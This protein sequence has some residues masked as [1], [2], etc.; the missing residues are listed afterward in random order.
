MV[1][2]ANGCT[3]A[4][5]GVITEPDEVTLS[6]APSPTTVKLGDE[7]QL[8]TTTN[9]TGILTYNWLPDNGLSCND[10]ANPVFSGIVSQTYTV[11]VTTLKGC[12]GVANFV[13]T[14][15]P[16]Y[17]VFIP[18]VFTPDNSTANDYWQIFGNLSAFK[19]ME[20]N[21]FNRWGE[22]VFS[23]QDVNFKWDGTY[24]GEKVPPGVYVYT[25]K[26]VWLNNHSDSNY[27]GT[28]TVLH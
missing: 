23:T 4:D 22:K 19:Q 16:N 21:V 13:V 26:F 8:T 27:H 15:V 28:V 2:D 25:A 5:V 14:V 3:V 10:C 18:N 12:V 11:T 20:M 6:V 9:Q 1:T 24:R 7:L 17:D